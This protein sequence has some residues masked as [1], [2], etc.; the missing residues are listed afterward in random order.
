MIVCIVIVRTIIGSSIVLGASFIGSGGI[1]VIYYLVKGNQY[2]RDE[3]KCREWIRQ[4]GE[5]NRLDW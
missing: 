2:D 3:Q 5:L 1:L 4:H